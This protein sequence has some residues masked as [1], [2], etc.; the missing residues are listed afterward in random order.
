MMVY[1]LGEV[2]RTLGGSLSVDRVLPPDSGFDGLSFALQ[3]GATTFAIAACCA[4]LL[5]GVREGAE[6]VSMESGMAKALPRGHWPS[7]S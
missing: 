4:V 6:R 2:V 3:V 1:A 5:R 7:R